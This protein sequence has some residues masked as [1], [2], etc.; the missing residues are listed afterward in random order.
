MKR[1]VFHVLA[2]VARL[3]IREDVERKVWEAR[4]TLDGADYGLGV[5][6]VDPE[7]RAIPYGEAF[8]HLVELARKFILDD[9][10]PAG[11]EVD[12][13]RAQ[14]AELETPKPDWNT[15]I[16]PSP[17][18]WIADEAG[19][20]RPYVGPKVE[21][22][23]VRV[24][25]NVIWITLEPLAGEIVFRPEIRAEDLARAPRTSSAL[26]D[27]AGHRNA[28]EEFRREPHFHLDPLVVE[29]VRV[30]EL[31]ERLAEKWQAEADDDCTDEDVEEAL[32]RAADELRRFVRG[33]RIPRQVEVEVDVQAFL[34]RVEA[35]ESGHFW[36]VL[37]SPGSDEWNATQ[38]LLEERGFGRHAKGWGFSK[39]PL[40]VRL[41]SSRS[42]PSRVAG[43][44]VD[45]VLGFVAG[46]ILEE[47][48]LRRRRSP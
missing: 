2:E 34:D 17:G 24:D 43:V 23:L 14:L 40:V 16:H 27:E 28:L 21:V 5:S 19:A 35:E 12:E 41:V 8:P 44:R 25:G 32:S 18:T 26:F 33:P 39:G 15:E 48:R 29:R 6:S 42:R 36:I 13:V 20:L 30:G 10:T 7:G 47:L 22:A 3:R 45:D 31:L 4:I 46:P 9:R 11:L 37:D 38:R 1:T